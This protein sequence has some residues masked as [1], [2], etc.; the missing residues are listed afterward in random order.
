MIEIHTKI[1][2]LY[3]EEMPDKRDPLHL[4]LYDSL[5]KYIFRFSI[6]NIKKN[7]GIEEYV[8]CILNF[9]LSIKSIEQFLE[10]ISIESYTA[11]EN[12]TDL[13]EDMFG[14]DN[15]DYDLDNDKY[16]LLLDGS[17]ITEERILKDPLVYKIGETYIYDCI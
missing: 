2:N 17:E 5:H 11:S 16:I 9:L 15:Y 8:C 14:L 7:R 4:N 10:F 3:L 1:G 6:E 13:L 12:W